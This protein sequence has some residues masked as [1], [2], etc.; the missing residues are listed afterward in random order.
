M[1]HPGSA[2]DPV[3]PMSVN[4]RKVL[5][6]ALKSVCRFLVR[7]TDLHRYGVGSPFALECELESI[8][9]RP[10][11]HLVPQSC[12]A[13]HGSPVNCDDDILFLDAGLVRRRIRGH[14]GDERTAVALGVEFCGQ[15]R[16]QILDG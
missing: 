15:L 2:L 16:G 13:A 12:T 11:T 5:E 8:A 6:Q 3:L 14:F 10:Q 7:W 9:D 1:C 4:Q